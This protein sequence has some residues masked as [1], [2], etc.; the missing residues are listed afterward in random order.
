MADLAMAPQG[1]SQPLFVRIEAQKR[2]SEV[3]GSPKPPYME[4]LPVIQ[5]QRVTAIFFDT[6][7]AVLF[8]V[9]RYHPALRSFVAKCSKLKAA[10][11]S[12]HYPS[13]CFISDDA[14]NVT[15]AQRRGLG[16]TFLQITG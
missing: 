12:R 7:H 16:R 2:A 9:V 11:M 14:A 13:E 15:T 3:P 8:S 1:L 10:H 5:Y 6:V 4:K